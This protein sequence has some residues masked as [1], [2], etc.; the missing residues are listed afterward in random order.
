VHK[1]ER[2]GR[3]SEE[4]NKSFNATL[5]EIN[6]RVKCVPMTKQRI[7]TTD[8]QTQGNLK[9]DILEEKISLKK[10]I[11]GKRRGP[12]KPR[13]RTLDNDA[14]VYT[15]RSI[16]VS[17]KGEEYF[18]LGSGNLIPKKWQDIYAWF[19]GG[20]APSEWRV[21]LDRTAPQAYTIKE[22]TREGFQ[23]SKYSSIVS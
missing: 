20:I 16:Y 9:G 10:A 13:V 17:F 22:R 14:P 1:Y 2:I 21:A 18:K 8:A 19:L 11:T 15:M 7:E 5:T 12:Q 3:V 4:S 6:Y 23:C